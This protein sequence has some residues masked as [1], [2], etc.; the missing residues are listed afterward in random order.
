[1]IALRVTGKKTARVDP[2][3]KRVG[4][5]IYEI[6]VT[7]GKDDETLILTP[8]VEGQNIASAKI[9]VVAKAAAHVINVAIVGNETSK[10]ANG[11]NYFDFKAT[12]QDDEG[13]AVADAT[14]IWSQDKGD[15]V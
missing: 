3:F 14:I 15:N 1:D 2:S 5:G 13:K 11:T 9:I 10:V 6:S 4:E 8:S 7:A 12:A